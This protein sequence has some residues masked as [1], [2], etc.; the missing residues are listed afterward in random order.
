MQFLDFFAARH[1]TGAAIPY[2]KATVYLTG[3]TTLAALFDADGGS[4]GNPITATVAGELG[5]AA[6]NGSYDIAIRAA[7]GGYSSPLI[8]RQQLYDLTQLDSQVAVAVGAAATATTEAGIATAAAA[9][10]VASNASLLDV[11]SV[12][13]SGIQ[14]TAV[15]LAAGMA[16]SLSADRMLE[17]V[18]FIDK[19]M[20]VDA[21]G[22]G[23]RPRNPIATFGYI[24]TP[25]PTVDT[26]VLFRAG[27]QHMIIPNSDGNSLYIGAGAHRVN[28][29]SYGPEGNYG[30]CL[31]T[32]MPLA[33][34][35]WTASG[36][37]WSTTVTLRNSLDFSG[38]ANIAGVHLMLWH[39]PAP[40]DDVLGD[41]CEL[42]IGGANPA[43]ND[44]A[45]DGT[46]GVT[47]WSIKYAGQTAGDIRGTSH[48]GDTY[49]LHIKMADG[50]NPNGKPLFLADYVSGVNLTTGSHGHVLIIGTTGKDSA[51]FNPAGG[52]SLGLIP[53]FE[54]LTFL[55]VGG[56]GGVGPKCTTGAFIAIG[57][58]IPGEATFATGQTGGGGCHN[59]SAGFDLTNQYLY[60]GSIHTKNFAIAGCYAHGSGG[61]GE[62]YRG[63]N[64]DGDIVQ[65]NCTTGLEIEI[66]LIEGFKHAGRLI[67]TNGQQGVNSYP[68]QYFQLA[69]RGGLFKPKNSQACYASFTGGGAR[70]I[71]L[72]SDDPEEIMVLDASQVN[73]GA[74]DFN[75]PTIFSRSGTDS[76]A[77][78]SLTLKHHEDRTVISAGVHKFSI[79]DAGFDPNRPYAHLTLI[80]S[81]L[82][83][84]WPSFDFAP[85]WPSSLYIDGNSEIGFHG[86]NWAAIEAA[87][88]AL[89]NPCT[90]LTGAK[91]VDAAGNVVDI[92]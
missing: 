3:T 76:D 18:T 57:V 87:M 52:V 5:F 50:S 55:G 74:P 20:G 61:G 36:G 64:V 7:D 72:G 62:G 9:A 10:A 70:E 69:G 15:S 28:I 35:T 44:T 41:Y 73:G 12:L 71:V 4:I 8:K 77:P 60:N 13:E 80:G 92:K 34:Q 16:R 56:H 79:P 68:G 27:Q 30:A 33:G 86:R 66:T 22:R 67:L 11:K 29:A 48:V 63:W 17:P 25:T 26:T 24:Y 53:W 78:P 59:Y 54:S 14:E 19:I 90:I 45:V 82:G 42:H 46:S 81:K 65:D 6:A 32:R 84:M 58:P 37:G 49:T 89:G 40:H 43:A 39:V 21:A 83:D 47:A 75:T 51:N 1:D 38:A 88:A 85:H 91:A 2:A 31:D 23:A